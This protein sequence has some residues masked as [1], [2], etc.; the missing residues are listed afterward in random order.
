MTRVSSSPTE[1]LGGVCY[2]SRF[3]DEI[4]I[5]NG[6]KW[7]PRVMTFQRWDVWYLVVVLLFV[8]KGE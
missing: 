2:I 3:P 6:N 7:V 8:G 4:G 1:F 5:E